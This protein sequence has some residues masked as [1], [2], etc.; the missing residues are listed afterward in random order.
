MVSKKKLTIEDFVSICTGSR[1]ITHN[2][3]RD[4]TTDFRYFKQDHSPGLRVVVNTLTFPVNDSYNL[5]PGQFSNK[6]ILMTFTVHHALESV[7]L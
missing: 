7:S 5:E 4:R 3:M 1:Y 6:T 2:L